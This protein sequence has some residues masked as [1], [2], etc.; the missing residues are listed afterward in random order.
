MRQQ[1]CTQQIPQGSRQR[2]TTPLLSNKQAK[3]ARRHLPSRRCPG[4]VPI[5]LTEAPRSRNP[6]TLDSS[7]FYF[8]RRRVKVLNVLRAQ[9]RRAWR[10]LKR[11]QLRDRARQVA[12]VILRE[13]SLF[14]REALTKTQNRKSGRK[15]KSGFRKTS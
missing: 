10:Y 8:N 13:S 5:G 7:S 11:A 14:K 4:T 3:C 9:R 1:Q 15:A 2:G 12:K 6:K